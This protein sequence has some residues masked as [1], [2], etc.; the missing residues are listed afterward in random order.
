MPHNIE[1]IAIGGNEIHIHLLIMTKRWL[2]I[3]DLIWNLKGKSSYDAKKEANFNLYWQKGYSIFTVS[4]KYV[5]KLI[6]YINNQ[7]KHMSF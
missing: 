6:F 1:L 7:E 4:D 2:S 5:E 3:P